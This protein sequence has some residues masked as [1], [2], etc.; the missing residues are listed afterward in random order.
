MSAGVAHTCSPW[1]SNFVSVAP[2]SLCL[3]NVKVT[4]NL[5]LLDFWVKR[6]SQQAHE[7]QTELIKFPGV[8]FVCSGFSSLRYLARSTQRSSINCVLSKQLSKEINSRT[9]VAVADP[10]K[11]EEKKKVYLR[12][13]EMKICVFR[14]KSLLNTITL[15]QK[16]IFT[17]I[18]FCLHLFFNFFQSLAVFHARKKN[19]KQNS[20][21]CS[22][23]GFVLISCDCFPTAFQCEQRRWLFVREPH[24][25]AAKLIM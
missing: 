8:E 13:I 22:P 9:A 15:R 10:K 19:W 21:Y 4:F 25:H 17:S 14:T 7:S 12:T 24:L 23:N 11:A 16:N 18:L 6:F 20:V 2:S 1:N 3:L 5:P